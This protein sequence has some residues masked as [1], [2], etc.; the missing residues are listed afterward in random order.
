MP[1][2]ICNYTFE[3]GLTFTV[4]KRNGKWLNFK[5]YVLNVADSQNDFNLQLYLLMCFHFH[6]FQGKRRR[7]LGGRKWAGGTRRSQNRQQRGGRFSLSL[8]KSFWSEQTKNGNLFQGWWI[9]PYVWKGSSRGLCSRWVQDVVGQQEVF[10][11]GLQTF[12]DSITSQICPFG[13]STYFDFAVFSTIGDYNDFKS[14]LLLQ[15]YVLS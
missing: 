6:F 13:L 5:V 4:F 7:D 15:R 11:R 9:Y 8:W 1:K 2:F 12:P 14:N 10:D 3:W